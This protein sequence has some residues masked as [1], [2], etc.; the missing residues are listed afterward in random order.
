M[1]AG[2]LEMVSVKSSVA[3]GRGVSVIYH[4]ERR[5]AQRW[6]GSFGKEIETYVGLAERLMN[7]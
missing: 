5:L 6:G 1:K 2:E 4:L 7:E 3:R